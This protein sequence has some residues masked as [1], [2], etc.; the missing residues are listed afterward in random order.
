MKKKKIL[1]WLLAIVS[2]LVG[3]FISF[4][5]WLSEGLGFYGGIISHIFCYIG[6]FAPVVSIV[7]VVL[8]G[9][10]LRKGDTKKAILLALV[11]LIYAGAVMGEL[12][13][14]EATATIRTEKNIA[15]YNE[16]MYGK[17]WDSAPAI[18][19]IPEGYQE[20]LNKFYASARDGLTESLVDLGAVAMADYYGDAGLD[21]IGFAMMDVNDDDVDELLIGTVAPVEG[22]TAIFCIYS[23]PEN[24]MVSVI[25]AEDEVHYLHAGEANGAY[26]AEIA[27]C[28][29]AWSLGFV[30]GE[31]VM[32]VTYQEITMDP[33]GRMTLEMIPFSRYK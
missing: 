15:A 13:I 1:F 27:G 8:G 31:S 2:I 17:G 11:G 10:K 19:G 18:D 25:S 14:E 3:L 30:E 12:L 6:M 16:Q 32:A 7:C 29:A 26:L 20:V 9:R 21:N 24:A 5:S 23:N 28:G 33:A 22:G 4:V